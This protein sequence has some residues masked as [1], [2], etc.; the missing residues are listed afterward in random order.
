MGAKREEPSDNCAMYQILY[1]VWILIPLTFFLLALWSKLEQMSGRPKKDHPGD[2]VRQGFFISG[3]VVVSIVIDHF[4][5]PYL[6]SSFS[7]VWVPYGLYEL[8]L[9]PLILYVAAISFG[10]SSDIRITKA[11][12]PSS[13]KGK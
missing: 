5:L 12:H 7:P 11:P 1:L 8:L 6:Y 4:L 9:L 10:P 13:K 3:C 2:L